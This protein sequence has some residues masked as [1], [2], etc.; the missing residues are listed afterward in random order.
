MADAG[1][2]LRPAVLL[3]GGERGW[4]GP[5]A[6]EAA[7]VRAELRAITRPVWLRRVD[8]LPATPIG[9]H[10]RRGD[11]RVARTP[12]EFLTGGSLRTPES[13]FVESLLA[14]RRVVGRAVPAF[15]VSDADDAELGELLGLD[16][17]RRISTGSAIADLLALSRARF[18]IASGG[19]TF[20]AW[21]A[22]L[23]Q[24]PAISHP[25]QSLRWFRLTHEAYVGECDPRAPL[26]PRLVAEI[27][28]TLGVSRDGVSVR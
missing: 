11:F 10:V 6:G 17:V 15:V 25:G 7:L 2:R 22:F 19:S 5:L 18:L 13:W 16:R 26:S 9:I 4:F 24:S 28:S 21:A 27:E 8:A 3:F 12:G 20:S 1:S 14:V 23:G